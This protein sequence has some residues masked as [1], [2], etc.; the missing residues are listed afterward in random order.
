MPLEENPYTVPHLKALNSGQKLWGGQRYGSTLSLWNS[1][2]KISILLH[3]SQLQRFIL[4]AFVWKLFLKGI[5]QKIPCPLMHNSKVNQNFCKID[6]RTRHLFPLVTMVL[7]YKETN[8]LF[9]QWI[10]VWNFFVT[11]I[12]NLRCFF[13]TVFAVMQGKEENFAHKSNHI[14]KMLGQFW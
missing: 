10:A 9:G 1:L 6:V 4:N 12:D 11:F 8:G 3:K 2:L 5:A 7:H 14:A 13:D